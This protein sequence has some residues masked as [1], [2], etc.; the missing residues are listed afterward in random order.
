MRR[1]TA[2]GVEQPFE[3]QGDDR[4]ADGAP[5]DPVPGGK[6]GFRGQAGTGRV[7]R[8]RDQPTQVIGDLTVLH[9]HVCPAP[10]LRVT[11]QVA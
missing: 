7:D 4:L 3:L 6:L 9:D 1:R 10:N 2:P 11:R 5:G 8:L